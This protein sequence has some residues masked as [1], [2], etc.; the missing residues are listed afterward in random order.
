MEN[1]GA[2]GKSGWPTSTSLDTCSLILPRVVSGVL[3]Y[4]TEVVENLKDGKQAGSNKQSHL[5]PNVSCGGRVLSAHSH[6]PCPHLCRP[7]HFVHTQQLRHFIG[8]L[9]LHCLIVE[10]FKEDIQ[11]QYILPGGK[12]ARTA[13][14]IPPGASWK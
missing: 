4:L 2:S 6:L 5:T 8:C 7:R 13:C 10:G 1:L 9:L 11:N 12:E 14:W 3:S